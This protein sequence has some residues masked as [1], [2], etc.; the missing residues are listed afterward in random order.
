MAAPGNDP[1]LSPMGFE[2]VRY[3]TQLSWARDGPF[4]IRCLGDA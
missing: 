2:E 1:F 3:Q 4:R